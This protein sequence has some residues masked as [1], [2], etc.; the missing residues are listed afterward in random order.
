MKYP[1]DLMSEVLYTHEEILEKVDELAKRINKDYCG[2]PLTV[3][4]TLKGAVF[5]FADLL[6]R[7]DI[8]CNFEFIKASS[9]IGNTTMTIGNVQITNVMNFPIENRHILIIEDI[10]DT[11]L[12]ADKLFKYFKKQDCAS[13]EICALLDKPSRRVVEITPKYRGFE[14]EDKFVIGYGLD[15]NESYRNIPFVGV[16]NE[17]YI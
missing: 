3:V 1:S 9:Y 11:G 15:Y 16:I 5:F 8:D 17:K 10:I 4:C 14:I 12:T 2:L 13:V 7:I 6:K